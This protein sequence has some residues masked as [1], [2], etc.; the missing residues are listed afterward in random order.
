MD[1]IR[2][3]AVRPGRMKAATCHPPQ[4]ALARP[5]P[6]YEMAMA[7]S[8]IRKTDESLQM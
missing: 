2:K 3:S 1:C 5:P 4:I 6:I 8:Q 7:S